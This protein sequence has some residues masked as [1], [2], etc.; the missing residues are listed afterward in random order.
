MHEKIP[1]SDIE[2]LVAK[3]QKGDEKSFATIFQEFFPKILR[4]TR[5]RV[6]ETEAEDIVS[7]IFLKVV[8]KLHLYKPDRKAGFNAWIFRISH[9]TIVDYY[10]QKKEILGLGDGEGAENFF[11]QIEDESPLPNES[12]NHHFDTERLYCIL[13]KMPS[14]QR[15]ILELK[16]LEGF[17][18][19]EIAHITGKTEGSIRVIQ[20]RAL[21][22]IRKMWKREG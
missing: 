13:K 12:A 7:D 8:E 2:I 10:R 17:S 15:E 14:H 3:A 21:R 18:N 20:L 16:Y 11:L 19:R 9:N 22:E 5:F 6:K 1:A 4:Y